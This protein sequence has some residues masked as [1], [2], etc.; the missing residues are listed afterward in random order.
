M[1]ITEKLQH[2]KWLNQVAKR[3]GYFQETEAQL[4]VCDKNNLPPISEK[5]TA[6][7]KDNRELLCVQS[8]ALEQNIWAELG[9]FSVKFIKVRDLLFCVS[10]SWMI[11]TLS[12]TATLVSRLVSAVSTNKSLNLIL[13]S[14]LIFD[15]CNTYYL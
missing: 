9:H 6:T 10:W 4:L 11:K 3:H 5:K 15:E 7:R 14:E 13:Y 2:E 8:L 1:L 12:D